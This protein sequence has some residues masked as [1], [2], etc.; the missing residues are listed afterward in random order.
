MSGVELTAVSVVYSAG[1]PWEQVG[2]DKLDLLLAPGDRV[3]VVGSNGAG[4]STLGE[5]LR[6]T[7]RPTTGT[8]TLG[9]V[10]LDRATERIAV[11]IQHTRLQLFG[12]TV[13]EELEAVAAHPDRI[14]SV[15]R[16]LDLEPLLTHR[17]DELSGGQQRC[18]GLAAALVRDADLLVLDEPMAGLD[19]RV[20]ALVIR[21]LASVDP[22]AIVVAVTHD[23]ASCLPILSQGRRGRVLS[24]A[25]GRL[26]EE[27]L[28]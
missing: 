11:V 19:E 3:L 9:G 6:G 13:A 12:A 14:P 23:L 15:A 20:A 17:I 10:P 18:V 27:S 1:T 28:T 22:E 16:A 26:H 4:K 5:V 8:A 21:A 25:D 24:V 7:V 2:L